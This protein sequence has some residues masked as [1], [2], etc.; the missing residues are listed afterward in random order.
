L[1]EGVAEGEPLGEKLGRADGLAEGESLGE[2]LG[3]VD[4]I[5]DGEPLG[6]ALGGF[7]S[8]F[9]FLLFLFLFLFF[10]SVLFPFVS[11]I[12]VPSSACTNSSIVTW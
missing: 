12:M 7:L 9:L 8:L 10:F 4:G 2:E 1:I 3:L 6:E 5:A 11:S